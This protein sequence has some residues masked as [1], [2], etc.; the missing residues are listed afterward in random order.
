MM[1][2]MKVNEMYTVHRVELLLSPKTG[3]ASNDNKNKK[4]QKK[5]AQINL[6]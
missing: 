5:T 2:E 3:L 1:N 6:R 4:I